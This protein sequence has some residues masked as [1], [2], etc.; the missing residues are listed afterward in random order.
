[1]DIFLLIYNDVNGGLL[2]NYEGKINIYTSSFGSA[3]T[4]PH[5]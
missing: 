4:F 5:Y 1:M 3:K 2:K